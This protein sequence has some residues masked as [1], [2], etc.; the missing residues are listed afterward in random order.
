M[1]VCV[2]CDTFI[3]QKEMPKSFLI[4]VGDFIKGKFHADKSFYFHAKYLT[5]EL[6][7][8]TLL[9]NLV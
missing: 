4:R 2:I 5:S 3:E 8:V 6:K 1:G 7:R 9:R